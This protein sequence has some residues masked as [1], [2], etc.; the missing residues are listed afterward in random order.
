MMVGTHNTVDVAIECQVHMG[1]TF[2]FF[3]KGGR[4]YLRN[5]VSM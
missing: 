1:I 4:R 3:R 2:G 5:A